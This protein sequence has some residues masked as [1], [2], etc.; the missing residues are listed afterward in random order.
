VSA[1]YPDP[2]TTDWVPLYRLVPT[3]L[4][5]YQDAKTA[6]AT[7]ATLKAAEPTYIDLLKP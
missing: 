5:S 1:L 2:Q 4:V 3:G 6:Y 7:Y